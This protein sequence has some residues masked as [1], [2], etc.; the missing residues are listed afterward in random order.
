AW[1]K[2]W[3]Y[4]AHDN[5][6]YW[7][8]MHRIRGIEGSSFFFRPLVTVFFGLSDTLGG[9]SP[10]FFHFSNVLLQALTSLVFFGIARQFLGRNLASFGAALVFAVHPSHCESV[11]WIAAVGDLLVGL[12]FGLAFYAHVRARQCDPGRVGG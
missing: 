12:F 3:S 9:G 5:D 6:S 4:S 8:A 1:W 11:Q 7:M 10:A 2:P